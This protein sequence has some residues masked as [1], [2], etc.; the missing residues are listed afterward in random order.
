MYTFVQKSINIVGVTLL[1][2][3]VSSLRTWILKE[4]LSFSEKNGSLCLDCAKKTVFIEHLFCFLGSASEYMLGIEYLISF[5]ARQ[6]STSVTMTH[7][8]EN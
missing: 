3:L 1:S 4:F 6:H 8:W 7:S 2:G 5:L